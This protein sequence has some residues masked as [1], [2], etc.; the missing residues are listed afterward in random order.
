MTKSALFMLFH[1]E[2]DQTRQRIATYQALTKPVASDVAIG[3]ISR[4]DALNNKSFSKI[5]LRE[6]EHKLRS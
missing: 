6:A 2:I 5:A 4:I 3:R 1:S